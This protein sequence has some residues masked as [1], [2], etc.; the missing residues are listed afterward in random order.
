MIASPTV[1]SAQTP[2]G[3][4]V[5]F[6]YRQRI[7]ITVMCVIAGLCG[8][9]LTIP[10]V[11]EG[12]SLDHY[13]D[14]LGYLLL[15][16]AIVLRLWA[17]GHISGRKSKMLVTGGLYAVCRNPQYIG[18]LLI[19]VSQ[20]LFLKSYPFALACVLPIV[21][22][23]VGVVPAEEHLLR[24]RFGTEYLNYC[25]RVPRWS[26]RWNALNLQWSRPLNWTAFQAECSRS[27]VL[28]KVVA[29]MS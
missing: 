2:C 17:S 25:R 11:R 1:T 26:P 23:A 19:A 27:E 13:C 4:K 12:S 7:S 20:I 14:G 21:L 24:E 5:S 28:S 29:E 6:A 15:V 8:T 22:Y 9:L 18:T 10:D 16:A 3:L